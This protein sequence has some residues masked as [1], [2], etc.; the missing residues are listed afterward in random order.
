MYNLPVIRTSA[1]RQAKDDRS[2]FRVVKTRPSPWMSAN[3][4]PNA[5]SHCSLWNTFPL[6]KVTSSSLGSILQR[7]KIQINKHIIRGF[8]VSPQPAIS[9][10]RWNDKC[11]NFQEIF[12][13]SRE[14]LHKSQNKTITNPSVGCYSPV[15]HF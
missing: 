9:V 11:L 5:C 14:C 13:L 10:F 15:C 8:E 7:N 1:E 4:S 2:T 6:Q 3:Q 12:I